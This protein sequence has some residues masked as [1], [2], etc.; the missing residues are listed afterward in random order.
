MQFD[1]DFVEMQKKA[2]ESLRQQFDLVIVDL[3]GLPSEENKQLL[4]LCDYYIL[5]A[6]TDNDPKIQSILKGWKKLLCELNLPALAE[7]ESSLSGQPE[8]FEE[9]EVFK[10]RLV[11]LDRAGVPEDTLSVIFRFVDWLVKRFG[12]EV[13]RMSKFSCEIRDFG[14]FLFVDV[15]IG[16]NGL[17]TPEE[18]PELLKVVKEAVGNKYFGKGVVISGRLPV[19]TH[20]AIAHLFHA[21]KFVAHFDPRLQGGVVVSTHDNNYKIGQVIPVQL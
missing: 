21:S 9:S 14:K 5:L 4:K 3:G 6:R 2:I 8:I 18:L 7:F 19:W 17:M 16:E 10:A 20:S 15:R 12:L 11:K 13:M 1:K